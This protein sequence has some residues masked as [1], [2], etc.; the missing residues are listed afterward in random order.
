MNWSEIIWNLSLQ[1][2]KMYL[3]FHNTYIH[4][5][6]HGG[7]LPPGLPTNKVAWP[8][9]HIVGQNTWQAKNVSLLSEC[10]KL[11]MTVTD[12]DWFLQIKSHYFL[13]VWSWKITWQFKI[14]IP[15]L[16]KPLWL[17][18]VAGWWLT[19]GSYP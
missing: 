17:P 18:N 5:T 6:W 9:D 1:P 19:L 10:E 4:Q 8:F 13:I 16:P 3:H 15:P 2:L 14:I 11:G 7:D 12:H